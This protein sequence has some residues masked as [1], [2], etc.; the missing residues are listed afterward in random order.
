MLNPKTLIAEADYLAGEKEAAIKHEYLAGEVYAMAGASKTHGTLALN[1]AVLLRQ[2]LRGKP[3]GVW[4]ADMK[5]RVASFSSY[6]YP[7]LVVT[8]DPDDLRPD[9][10]QDYLQSP[11]LIIEV[12]S[13]STETIDRREKL[14]AYRQL[15][16]LQEYVLID[17]ARPWVEIYRR[18][19]S[20]WLHQVIQAAEWID[21]QSIGLNLS[22][23]ELYQETGLDN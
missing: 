20:G 8:C 13:E 4:M 23:N 12:L 6:Y 3:C 19:K 9:A 11:C 17:Q 16:S 1:A 5:V 21:L 2:H 7:D 15:H 22:I 14:Q 18:G 10:P